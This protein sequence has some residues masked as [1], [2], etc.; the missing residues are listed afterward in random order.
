MPPALLEQLAPGGRLIA[1]VGGA[2]SQE[3]LLYRK[4]ADGRISSQD[5]LPVMFV[6]LVDRDGGEPPGTAGDV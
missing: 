5:L 3:L 4:T 6:P 2:F 1:P